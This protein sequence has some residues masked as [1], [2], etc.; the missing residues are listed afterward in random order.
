MSRF[1]RVG[2]AIVAF[3]VSLLV[4]V[5][6]ASAAT[7]TW[8]GGTNNNFN[9]AANWS[10]G[11]VPTSADNIV[12]DNTAIGASKVLNNDV[13]SLGVGSIT[14]S[15]TNSSFYNFTIGGNPMSLSG[16]IIVT[17][18]SSPAITLGLT[19]T[20]NQSIS[21]TGGLTLYNSTT[22]TALNLN[23]HNLTVSLADGIG[24]GINSSISGTGNISVSASSSFGLPDTSPSWTGSLNIASGASVYGL[25]GGSLGNVANAVTVASGGNLSFCGANGATV[26]QPITVGG[27]GVGSNGALN[28]YVGCNGPSSSTAVITLGGTLT[29]T[30]DTTVNASDTFTVT[31]P[32]TGAHTLTMAGGA[33]GT[34]VINS[35]NNQSSTPNGSAQSPVTSVTY[36][37]NSPGTSLTLGTNQT[38]IVDGI[39]GFVDLN[40]G[41]LKGTGTI[42]QLFVSSGIVAPGHSPGVLNTGDLSFNGGTYQ[43]EIG[44]TAAGQFDQ[45]NVTGT[46]DLGTNVTTLDTSLYGGFVPKA[47]NSFVII[48]NDAADAAT[49]TFKNLAEGATFTVAGV[50]FKI[51][52]VGGDG[53]D[54]VLTA[55]TVPALPKTGYS[56]PL[57]N[58]YLVLLATLLMTGT[59]AF[60]AWYVGVKRNRLF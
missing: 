30:A 3:G 44:G 23:G 32:I 15:G 13:A 50:V 57:G 39:Y 45:L 33:A 7:I 31:G 21:G 9:T 35:S 24:G 47:G 1:A 49:G 22:P 28:S 8:L 37:A 19:L 10:S 16:G 34:L 36:A 27:T 2:V 56:L 29:L 54:V 14:F 18:N 4:H 5:P 41:T 46:V 43:V 52:Y 55:V 17:S 48:N 42:G 25:D 38:G 11:T 58:A 60:G 12:F 53:N 51:S 6:V 59:L 20:A 40:G 26:S